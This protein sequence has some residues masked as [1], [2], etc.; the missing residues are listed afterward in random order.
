MRLS[1]LAIRCERRSS[2]RNEGGDSLE[3]QGF[4]DLFPL[5]VRDHQIGVGMNI[6]EARADHPPLCLYDFGSLGSLQSAHGDDLAAG[7]G[8]IPRVG[9]RTG[10]VHNQA[11]SDDQINHEIGPRCSRTSPPGSYR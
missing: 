3:D 8:H 1:R 6:D 11:I 9:I 5:R 2:G 10:P 4:E 7:H